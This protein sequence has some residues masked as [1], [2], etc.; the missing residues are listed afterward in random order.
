M[1]YY[2]QQRHVILGWGGVE[3]NTVKAQLR[4]PLAGLGPIKVPI[5]RALAVTKTAAAVATLVKWLLW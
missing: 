1:E 5:G 2:K 4:S 3:G